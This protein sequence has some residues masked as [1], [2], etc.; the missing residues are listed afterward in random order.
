MLGVSAGIGVEDS[1]RDV[2]GRADGDG[3]LVVGGTGCMKLGWK[4]G[5]SAVAAC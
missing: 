1:S 4:S 3:A 5:C 2:I